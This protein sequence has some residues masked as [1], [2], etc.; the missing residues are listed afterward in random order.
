MKPKIKETA[1]GCGRQKFVELTNNTQ[2]TY[3][4]SFRDSWMH[5]SVSYTYALYIQ[6]MLGD[7][8]K[9][10][11]LFCC[12]FAVFSLSTQKV[13]SGLGFLVYTTAQP[14]FQLACLSK[15][16]HSITP[17][18]IRPS[19]FSHTLLLWLPNSLFCSASNHQLIPNIRKTVKYVVLA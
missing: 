11:K 8:S 15:P 4:L 19:P 2:T 14:W 17:L 7:K 9:K 13:P 1:L 3:D 18:L 12:S 5:G 16:R 10:K 6:W